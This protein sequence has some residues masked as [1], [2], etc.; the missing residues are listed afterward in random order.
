MGMARVPLITSYTTVRRTRSG[1]L[2]T[3]HGAC[4]HCSFT[5]ESSYWGAVLDE[6]IW[7]AKGRCR[8]RKGY[9]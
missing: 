2:K 5:I 8:I 3:W 4:N 1:L 7:H 6:M 9:W